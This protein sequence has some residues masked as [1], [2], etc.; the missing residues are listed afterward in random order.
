MRPELPMP[1]VPQRRDLPLAL[2]HESRMPAMP[3]DLLEGSGRDARRHVSRFRSRRRVVPGLLGH[4]RTRHA[5]VRQRPDFYSERDSLQHRPAMLP[6]NAQRLDRA[7]LS[8]RRNGTPAPAHNP[9]RQKIRLIYPISLLSAA[10]HRTP[11]QLFL[12]MT[13]PFRSRRDSLVTLRKRKSNL[14]MPEFRP[15]IEA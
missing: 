6:A 5:S 15:M 14:P 13:Q 3:R 1:G 11:R 10:A 7:G 8:V 12:Q 4:S 9:R 2:P